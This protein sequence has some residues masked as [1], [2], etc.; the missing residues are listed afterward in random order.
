MITSIKNTKIKIIRGLLNAKKH[1]EQTHTMVVEGVRLAEET[2]KAN[3]AIHFCLYC[4]RISERGKK[5]VRQIQALSYDTEK[6][7]ADLMDR[8]SDTK[9]SQ[10]VLLAVPYPEVPLQKNVDPVIVLDGI[11]DPG[12]LGTILRTAAAMNIGVALLTPGTTDPFSPKVMRA[13]MG[14]QFHLPIQYMGAQD[15]QSFCK[16]INGIELSILIADSSS[17]KIC[18]KADLSKPVCIVIGNEAEGVSTDIREIAEESISIPM[19]SLTESF[20]AAIAASIL[21]YEINRQRT[22]K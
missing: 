22:N 12:N 16:S 18:W 1:R 11:R 21:M 17:P 14:A 10:G 9:N 2:L 8:I 5:V 7:S 6:V 13:A 4:D 15:I 3:A 19:G 20:N